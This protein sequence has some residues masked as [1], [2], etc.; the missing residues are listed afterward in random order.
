M[1]LRATLIKIRQSVF[2]FLSIACFLAFS[3]TAKAIDI[4]EVTSP[5]GIKAWLVE[6]HEIPLIAMNFAFNGGSLSDAPGKEGTGKFL[7]GMMD[8]GAGDMDG[9]AFRTLRDRL[10]ISISFSA[11]AE[12]FYGDLYTLS[13]NREAAFNL[14][15]KAVTAPRFEAEPLDRM[16][17]YYLQQAADALKDPGT[18]Q[19]QCRRHH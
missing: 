5:G 6:A 8:E 16:R 13:K 4:Q 10:S 19:P 2:M 12:N 17:K 3:T 1:E 15:T 7:T 9:P 11:A 14:L 18:L